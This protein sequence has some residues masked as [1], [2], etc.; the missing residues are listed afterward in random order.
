MN[1]LAACYR[2]TAIIG[3]EVSIIAIKRSPRYTLGT[4]TGFLTSA[5]IIIGTVTVLITLT[6]RYRGKHTTGTGITGIYRT[7]VTIITAYRISRL[8]GPVCTLIPCRADITIIT[9]RSIVDILTSRH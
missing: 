3:T 5:N 6:T 7:A 4:Y 9:G 8:T 1:M 2:I